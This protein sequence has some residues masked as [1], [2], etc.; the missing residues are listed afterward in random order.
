MSDVKIVSG[1]HF[2]F[3]CDFSDARLSGHFY[4][5]HGEEDLVKSVISDTDGLAKKKKL[6]FLMFRGDFKHNES[7]LK[8]GKG[9]FVIARSEDKD[10]GKF[11]DFRPCIYCKGFFKKG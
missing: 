1:V 5:S 10:N 11:T 3:F 7:V 9:L 8:S 2:C 6:Q 4:K